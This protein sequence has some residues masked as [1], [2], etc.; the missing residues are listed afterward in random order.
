MHPNFLLGYLLLAG[1]VRHNEE[2]LVIQEVLK[3][4]FKRNVDPN[5]LFDLHKETSLVTRHILTRCID[6]DFSETD[7]SNI[8]WTRNLR[9]LAVLAGKAMEFNEPCLL[10]GNTG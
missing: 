6:T 9:R 1:R 4:H 10:V 5:K 2:A 8:V 7:Y 3:K